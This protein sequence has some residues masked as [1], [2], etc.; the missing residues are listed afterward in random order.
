V[1]AR[2]VIGVDLGGTKILA[3]VLDEDG[4]V[5]RLSERPTPTSS[6]EALLDALV[7][8]VEEVREPGIQAVGFGI[9]ARIDQRTGEA[10]GAVNTPIHHVRLRDELEDRLGMRVGVIN[11]GSAAALA[12]FVHGAGRGTHDLVLLTLGTGVGGG[13]V[14]AGRLYA[15]WAEVGHMVI[16]EGGEPCQGAC[17]G[18][19]HVESYC[20]GLAAD[21]LARSLLGPSATA[22]DLVEQRHPAL[23]GIGRHLGAAI[24]SLVNLFDPDM[25]VVG[26]GFGVAAGELLLAPARDVMLRDALAPAGETV[27]L[28]IAELGPEAGLIGAG[29]VAFGA[30]TQE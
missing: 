7:E 10:L 15:G 1:S 18:R 26:G 22:R 16:V 9:P 20:S 14:F 17:T 13:F 19:G 25:V 12:E 24:A 29:L 23:E 4:N 2:R 11:D 28:V 5:E 21:R 3:G 8:T 27:G 6:Q 30:L